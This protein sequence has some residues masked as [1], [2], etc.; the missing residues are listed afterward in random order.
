ML[1]GADIGCPRRIAALLTEPLATTVPMQDP[2]L[3]A[4]GGSGDTSMTVEV[5]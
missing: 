2:V 1:S 5:F 3:F 4:S